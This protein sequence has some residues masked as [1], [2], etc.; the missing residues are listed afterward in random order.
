[1]ALVGENSL[2]KAAQLIKGDALFW[3]ITDLKEHWSESQTHILTQWCP[4][5][6]YFSSLH[7][8]T[9]FY[10][11]INKIQWPL[12]VFGNLSDTLNMDVTV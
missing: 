11:C 9:S 4:H 8:K 5:S 6:Y 3:V 12:N 1:M 7:Y 10:S 2:D